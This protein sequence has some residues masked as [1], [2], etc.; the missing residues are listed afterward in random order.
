MNQ[1]PSLK[2]FNDVKVFAGAVTVA[3]ASYKNLFWETFTDI[4]INIHTPTI[5][6]QENTMPEMPE[7]HILYSFI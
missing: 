6:S 4:F 7:M 2:P 3:D 1:N 5:V